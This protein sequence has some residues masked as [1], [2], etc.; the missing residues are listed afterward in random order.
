MVMLVLVGEY[1]T[2][3]AAAQALRDAGYYRIGKPRS[4]GYTT[5]YGYGNDKGEVMTL[6]ER[7]SF[8][9]SEVWIK[10]GRVVSRYDQNGDEF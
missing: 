3:Q 2:R 1:D 9:T 7:E 5:A 10:R 6:L 8:S 4:E